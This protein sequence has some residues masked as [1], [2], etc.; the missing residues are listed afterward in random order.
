[1]PQ[2]ANITVNNGATTPVSKLFTL[3]TPAA[4][5]RGLAIWALKEGA[6]PAVFPKFTAM[7]YATGNRSRKSQ[8]K[9]HLPYSY[10][11]STTGL[12]KAGPAFEFNGD[13]TVPDEFPEALRADAVAYTANLI[14]N[15]IIKEM[16]RDGYPAV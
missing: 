3:M 16:I 6:S 14:A 9:L 4:G 2:A 10:T 8:L 5:D 15:A 7:A 12:A 11:D 1:M 13:F